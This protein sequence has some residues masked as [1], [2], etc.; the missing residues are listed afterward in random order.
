MT[1]DRTVRL[2]V[3]LNILILVWTL[4]GVLGLAMWISVMTFGHAITITVDGHTHV[5]YMGKAE[6]P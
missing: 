6:R 5:V 2:P 1:E 4:I 3:N